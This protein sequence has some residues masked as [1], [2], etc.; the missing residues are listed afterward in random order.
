MGKW[1]N[2]ENLSSRRDLVVHQ[3]H[4]TSIRSKPG[5]AAQTLGR[6]RGYSSTLEKTWSRCNVHLFKKHF[7]I[8][9]VEFLCA[10]RGV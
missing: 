9:I 7:R 2:Y 6:A 4:S 1:F 8:A 5:T 3:S 10:P